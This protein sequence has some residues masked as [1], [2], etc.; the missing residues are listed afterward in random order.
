[1]RE[2][3]PG[4]TSGGCPEGRDQFSGSTTSAGFELRRKSAPM[5]PSAAIAAERLAEHHRLGGGKLVTGCASS[6]RRFRA[7]GEDAEDL[8]T[9]V[10][11]GLGVAAGAP[12]P[13]R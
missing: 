6:L 11:R 10:A 5:R 7:S 1:M 2:V 8:V 9:W 4:T 13:E 12:T 3:R